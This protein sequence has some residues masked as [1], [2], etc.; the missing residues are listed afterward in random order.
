MESYEA[1]SIDR[2]LILVIETGIQKWSAMNDIHSIRLFGTVPCN[3][4]G[5]QT[6]LPTKYT[7]R[8]LSLLNGAFNMLNVFMV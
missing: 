2:L 1:D 6:P 7:T 5:M 4:A 8:K 3:D